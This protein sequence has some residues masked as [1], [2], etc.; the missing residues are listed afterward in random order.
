[1]P[2]SSGDVMRGNAYL[3]RPGEKM[4]EV[5][6]LDAIQ[7]P[8]GIRTNAYFGQALLYSAMPS[9]PEARVADPANNDQQR[10]QFTSSVS[11]VMHCTHSEL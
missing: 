6:V 5:D 1:V 11:M 4:R 10:Q 7:T 9:M 2:T 3:T 8:T